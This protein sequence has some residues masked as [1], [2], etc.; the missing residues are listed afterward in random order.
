[1]DAQTYLRVFS[2]EVRWRLPRPEADEVLADYEDML[3]QRAQG[4]GDLLL[5]EF[6]DPR[7][8]A[9]LLTDSKSYRYWLAGFTMMLACLLVLWLM[10]LRV[11]VFRPSAEVILVFWGIGL[12]SS[13][14]WFHRPRKEQER[15]PLPKGLR[16]TLLGLA[17]VCVIASLILTGLL[18]QFWTSLPLS[19]YGPLAHGAMELTGGIAAAAGIFGLVKARM[20]ERRWQA[21]YGAA[22]LIL[23]ECALVMTIL[24]S[25]SSLTPGWWVSGAIIMGITAFAG[26]AGIG[27]SLC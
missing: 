13:F 18:V 8:A 20:S 24:T 17:G 27:V 14:L 9:R 7:L 3:S 15:S 22:L 2:R 19:S 5:Q 23:A 26:F 16:L 10:L 21:V 12:A 1:M 4:R 11:N 6:G 25:L